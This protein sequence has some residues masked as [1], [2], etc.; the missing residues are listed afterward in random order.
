MAGFDKPLCDNAGPGM[1]EGAFGF[2]ELLEAEG[3]VD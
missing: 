1:N 3:G 2:S